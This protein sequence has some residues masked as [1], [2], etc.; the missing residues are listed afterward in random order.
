MT[1]L[2]GF[3]FSI[4][5]LIDNGI[6]WT[7]G[8]HFANN[9]YAFVVNSSQATKSLGSGTFIQTIGFVPSLELAITV[10]FLVIFSIVLYYHRKNDI[11]NTFKT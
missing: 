8:A 2:I 9:F 3:I 6:E 11:I 1:F 5:V 7:V 4:V 10:I